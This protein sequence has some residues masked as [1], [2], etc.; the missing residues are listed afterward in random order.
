[1]RKMELPIPP[2][3][4]SLISLSPSS[5][6]TNKP[7]KICRRKGKAKKG[8]GPEFSP[9]RTESVK[10]PI[11]I[12]PMSKSCIIATTSRLG[13]G[14]TRQDLCQRKIAGKGG[15]GKEGGGRERGG[16]KKLFKAS[17]SNFLLSTLRSLARVIYYVRM[18]YMTCIPVIRGVVVC[19]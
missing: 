3:L 2:Y 7:G 15:E 5:Y 14:R 9:G 17:R 4:P 18:S 6:S 13:F 11:L 10:P 8:G 16:E 12:L 1:M 19:L